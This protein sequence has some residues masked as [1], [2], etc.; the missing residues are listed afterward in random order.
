MA[1]RR[2]SSCGPVPTRCAA[3]QHVALRCNTTGLRCNTTGLRCN[4]TGLA[5][6]RCNRAG[7][8]NAPAYRAALADGDHE[9]C[10]AAL[11]RGTQAIALSVVRTNIPPAPPV[12][13]FGG[14]RRASRADASLAAAQAGGQSSLHSRAARGRRTRGRSSPTPLSHTRRACARARSQKLSFVCSRSSARPE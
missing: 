1:K 13:K 7:R 9:P 11:R 5:P 3:L 10:R 12:R 4:T 8:A 14:M 2:R 6:R